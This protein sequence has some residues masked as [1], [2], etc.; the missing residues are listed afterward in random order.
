MVRA[1]DLAAHPLVQLKSGFP[2][3]DWESV[4]EVAY[5]CVNQAGEDNRNIGRMALLLA[6]LP[7]SVPGVTLNRLCAS[8]MAAIA[9]VAN[10][11]SV[12]EYSLA[13]AGGVESMSRSPFV[14]PKATSAF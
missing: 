7:I 14:M 8:G 3:V 11:I 5:G 12:G 2:S 9:N 4:G 6:G 13:I 10:A 1:D